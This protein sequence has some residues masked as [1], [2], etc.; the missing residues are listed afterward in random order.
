MLK[1]DVYSDSICPWCI[2]GT[3]RLDKVL[4][5]RFPGLDVDIEHLPFVLHPGAP[6]EGFRIDEYF[7]RKGIADPTIA[8]ARPEAEASASRLALDLGKQPLGYRTV[9]A[10]TLLRYARARGTQHDLSM[11]LMDA[12]FHAA[13]NI[14]D[15]DV[16]AE[17]AARHGFTAGEAQAILADPAEQAETERQTAASRARG[18]RSVPTFDIEGVVIGGGSEDEIA[19]AIAQARR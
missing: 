4:R 18:V 13:R 6:P 12:N 19:A 11:A 1:I 10:H 15:K 8:F 7:R 17:I 5:E 14:S 3:H 2:I 16:L 9:H